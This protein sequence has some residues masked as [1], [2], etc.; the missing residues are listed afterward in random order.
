MDLPNYKFE[1]YDS[2]NRYFDEWTRNDQTEIKKPYASYRGGIHKFL[3]NNEMKLEGNS[4]RYGAKIAYEMYRDLNSF[5]EKVNNHI[6]TATR[7]GREE[8]V[9]VAYIMRSKEDAEFLNKVL[10]PKGIPLIWNFEDPFKR[11]VYDRKEKEEKYKYLSILC[12]MNHETYEASKY[13]KNGELDM[14]LLDSKIKENRSIIINHKNIVYYDL[15]KHNELIKGFIHT[16]RFRDY[17]VSVYKGYESPD[18]IERLSSNIDFN[19]YIV[20]LYRISKNED[21]FYAMLGQEEEWKKA[22][23]SPMYTISVELGNLLGTKE[24]VSK[25]GND[26]DT[27]KGNEELDKILGWKSTRIVPVEKPNE[28]G[29]YYDNI[30]LEDYK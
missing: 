19:D 23:F 15:S 2:L 18:I 10:T 21:A 5:V 24:K 25:K 14:E 27:D 1:G 3:Y 4:K 20:K 22:F 7:K 26:R 17:L 12:D 29:V 13:I 8:P 9:E 16:R 11:V 28:T 30:S 6:K